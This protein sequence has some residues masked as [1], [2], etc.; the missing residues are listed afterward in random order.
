MLA[1]LGSLSLSENV[2]YLYVI[3]VHKLDG[4]G[5]SVT[6]VIALAREDDDSAA[7]LHS[8]ANDRGNGLTATLHESHDRHAK[9]VLR[10][11]IYFGYQF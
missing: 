10:V 7:L 8:M 6:A 3:G 4:R 5:I 2:Y 11:G 9:G 1:L